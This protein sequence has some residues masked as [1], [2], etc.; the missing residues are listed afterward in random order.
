MPQLAGGG[1][2]STY[3]ENTYT[4]AYGLYA[5]QKKKRPDVVLAPDAAI[6]AIERESAHLIP[7]SLVW[8]MTNAGMRESELK[9][10]A[11][12]TARYFDTDPVWM[13][14]SLGIPNLGT[15]YETGALKEYRD[16]YTQGQMSLASFR[17]MSD[18]AE[19]GFLRA[20]LPD[21]VSATGIASLTAASK[22]EQA[23]GEG[24]PRIKA[25]ALSKML[26]GLR[27]ILDGFNLPA[28]L[29]IAMAV[30]ATKAGVSPQR[31]AANL[32]AVL[33]MGGDLDQA[34]RFLVA[35]EL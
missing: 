13:W 26:P 31:M 23:R 34:Q 29:G 35:L 30:E 6:T 11:K 18:D 28:S 8:A 15:A 33:A 2:A 21:L 4:E 5:G 25:E 20:I 7:S 10:A 32:R 22:A 27:P 17:R 12:L 16:P 19:P 9:Q 1:S 3:E 24:L 14:R